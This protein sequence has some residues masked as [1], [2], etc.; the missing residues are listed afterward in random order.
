MFFTL[1]VLCCGCGATQ[2]EVAKDSP[3]TLAQCE[4]MVVAAGN[5]TQANDQNAATLFLMVAKRGGC[6]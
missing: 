5:A 1:G 2:S 4:A 3:F 6:Y